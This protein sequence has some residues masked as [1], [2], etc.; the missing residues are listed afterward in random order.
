MT[1]HSHRFHR[2]PSDEGALEKDKHMLV[3]IHNAFNASVSKCSRKAA[4]EAEIDVTEEG[5]SLNFNMLGKGGRPPRGRGPCT[6]YVDAL[7][8][9]VDTRLCDRRG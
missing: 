4:N 5:G 9:S 3:P 8:A 2:A 6:L 7:K 1:H